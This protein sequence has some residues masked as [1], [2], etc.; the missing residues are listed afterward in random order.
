MGWAVRLLDREGAKFRT[1]S[2]AVYPSGSLDSW[3]GLKL[4]LPAFLPSPFHWDEGLV[5]LGNLISV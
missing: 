1:F 4:G 2:A 3:Q 5:V